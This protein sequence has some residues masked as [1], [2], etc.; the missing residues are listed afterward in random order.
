MRLLLTFALLALATWLVIVMWLSV[1][2]SSGERLL[3]LP[4]RYLNE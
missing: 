1:D 2:I 3:G 4:A